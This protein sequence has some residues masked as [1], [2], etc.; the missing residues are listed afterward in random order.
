MN[1]TTFFAIVQCTVAFAF[2]TIIT[3]HH[4]LDRALD[5]RLV[6]HVDQLKQRRRDG[7]PLYPP[8]LF[9]LP[10]PGGDICLIVDENENYHA[11]RDSFP[12]L[13]LRISESGI[14][15]SQVCSVRFGCWR[16]YQAR[17]DLPHQAQYT[18]GRH[19]DYTDYSI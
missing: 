10:S 18:V 17:L 2:T 13:R 4:D 1:I 11:I 19:P 7:A 16:L 6:D 14:V 8:H 5:F 9:S 12:P 15:D 3:N